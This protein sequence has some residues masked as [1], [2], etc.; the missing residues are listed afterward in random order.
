M[1]VT[2]TNTFVFI[3]FVCFFE[4]L[5]ELLLSQDRNWRNVPKLD[6]LRMFSHSLFTQFLECRKSTCLSTFLS[7]I[8]WLIS[9][10]IILKSWIFLEHWICFPAETFMI[11]CYNFQIEGILACYHN[12]NNSSRTWDIYL[13][14]SW[15]KDTWLDNTTI[16]L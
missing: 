5:Y 11:H 15:R 10:F 16:T 12:K 13:L 9:Q 14:F 2:F 3:V 8:F 4:G 6:L 7:S 1:D